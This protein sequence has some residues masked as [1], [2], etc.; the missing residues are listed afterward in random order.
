MLP[1]GTEGYA[2]Y[3]PASVRLVGDRDLG[4]VSRVQ[5]WLFSSEDDE[6]GVV[7]S[8]CGGEDWFINVRFE[9]FHKGALLV[10]PDYL[11]VRDIVLLD[12]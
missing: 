7:G 5:A 8:E 1:V 11:R 4:Q 9:E 6:A 3:G 12:G 2:A 10:G